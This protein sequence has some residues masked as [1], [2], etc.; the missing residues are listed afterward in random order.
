MVGVFWNN[1]VMVLIGVHFKQLLELRL[2]L[3]HSSLWV[4][5]KHVSHEVILSV[6][7]EFELNCILSRQSF[8]L[9][10]PSSAK[11]WIFMRVLFFNHIT[12]YELWDI[13]LMHLSSCSD[14]SSQI[15]TPWVLVFHRTLD[16][17]S[18]CEKLPQCRVTHRLIWELCEMRWLPYILHRLLHSSGSS[19][20]DFLLNFLKISTQLFDDPVYLLGTHAYFLQTFLQVSQRLLHRVVHF[21]IQCCKFI[22]R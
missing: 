4:I 21:L 14:L 6:E 7:C 18:S 11:W 16:G 9:S 3:S 5:L 19:G 15:H 2:S 1:K 22:K 13:L 10:L 8:Y 17:G 12:F 20:A